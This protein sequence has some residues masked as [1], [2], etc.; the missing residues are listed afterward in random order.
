[1]A[2]GDQPC[3]GPPGPWASWGEPM[4]VALDLARLAADQ[5]EIPVGCLVLDERGVIVGQGANG[6]I[7]G[8][9]P[10]AHAEILAIR[11]AA[12]A[13]SNYRI[14]GCVV[15]STLEPCLMCL[16]AMIHA[17]I[18]GLVYAAPDPRTGTVTSRLRGHELSWTN[19]RFWV[20]SNILA[21][22]SSA[23]LKAFFHSRRSALGGSPSS[24]ER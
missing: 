7:V 12:A 8:H 24:T 21:D 11:Q 2:Y 10:T 16:G 3:E 9:D 22:E 14:P 20:V 15:V 6:S 18:A 13:T 1:M 5:G 4:V 23:L 19:H 17:R